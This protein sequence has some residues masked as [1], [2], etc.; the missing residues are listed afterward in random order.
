MNRKEQILLY[1]SNMWMF[2]EGM[3][4]PLIAVF[5]ER[6]GGSILDI[7]WA[8]A[9]YLMV[10]GVIVI[11]VGSF[12]DRYSKEKI[13]VFGYGLAA[14][15]TFS[16]LLVETPI[17]LFLVQA[18]LGLAVGLANP[19]WLALYDEYSD[20]K[21]DGWLWGL[22]DGEARIFNG[23]AI[24]IGGLIVSRFSFEILFITMGM[25][26]FLTTLYLLRILKTTQ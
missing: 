14:L 24:V 20:D 11:I 18:G 22:A 17:H 15:L 10:T 26:Q 25:L 16:Y 6:I 8:W 4:G 23:V 13:M 5:T 3:F 12:S 21:E 2:A 9:T 7:S 19:T 1:G